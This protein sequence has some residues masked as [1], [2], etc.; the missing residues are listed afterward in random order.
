MP[1]AYFPHTPSM[2]VRVLV[3]TLPVLGVLAIPAVAVAAA[4]AWL[5]G[6]PLLTAGH[7]LPGLLCSL[8]VWLFVAVLHFRQERFRVAVTDPV[9]WLEEVRAQLLKM[10]Y[11]VRL[12]T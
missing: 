11:A 12:Q 6:T 8:G 9:A 5:Y 3:L 2:A 1:P 7:W 10:G 4:A